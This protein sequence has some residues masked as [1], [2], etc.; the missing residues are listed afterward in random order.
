[1]SWGEGMLFFTS[2]WKQPLHVISGGSEQFWSLYI[3]KCRHNNK[4]QPFIC[5]W[6]KVSITFL[7]LMSFWCIWSIS[8][9]T[10]S[11]PIIF[12]NPPPSSREVTVTRK[13]S[14]YF[15]TSFKHSDAGGELQVESNLLKMGRCFFTILAALFTFASAQFIPPVSDIY[16]DSS[17]C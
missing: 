3:A 1:M 11:L 14:G 5:S 12:R 15:R 7:I 2:V 6:H 8:C 13:N 9:I 4:F 10:K 17:S 16:A